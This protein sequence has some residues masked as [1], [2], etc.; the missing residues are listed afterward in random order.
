M[1]AQ[2][3][4]AVAITGGSASGVSISG[5]SIN[6]AP[7]GQ[8][9][10]ASGRFTD[11]RSDSLGVG[12]A[13]GVEVARFLRTVA[14]TNDCVAQITANTATGIQVGGLRLLYKRGVNMSVLN[15][16]FI[17]FAA[18]SLDRPQ[19]VTGRIQSITSNL[20]Q[21]SIRVAVFDGA[22]QALYDFD[23]LGTLNVPGSYRVL[24]L[25]V[26]AAR[27]T[28]W[29]VPSGAATRTTFNTGTVTLAQLAE[30]MKALIDDLTSHGLIGA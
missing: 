2:S 10:Q 17:E 9:T 12:E 21:N 13:A 20:G 7:I 5:G 1:A 28:G 22:S 14:T 4:G 6:A 26:V 3:P 29:G 18:E 23:R 11:L 27:R 8:T 15:G 30:R 25:Q 24:G 16:T 19:Y